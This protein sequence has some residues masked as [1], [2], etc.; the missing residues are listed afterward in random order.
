MQTVAVIDYGSSNLRS[1]SKALE[2]VADK[3]SVIVVSESAEEILSADR[4]VFPGQ[5]AIGQCMDNMIS[6]GLD[7]VVRECIRNKPFLGI[8]LGLQTLMEHS[9]E[10]GGTRG[11]EVI[12]GMVK[13]FADNQ[14]DEKGQA[15]KIP[16]MGWNCVSQT[17]LHPL[18]AGIDDDT[19]FYFVHSYYVAADLESDITG[20]S[21]YIQDFTAALGR[22]NI[23][24]TQF[25]PEKSQH[26]GLQLLRNFLQWKP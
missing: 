12:P 9:E 23:F 8:C 21:N 11:L 14:P 6:K 15:F 26:A 3:E 18:W 17:Q 7:E 13:R 5:G 1:V 24:A 2:H 19:R 4:V 20:S 10:D 22:D 25:H 16:H